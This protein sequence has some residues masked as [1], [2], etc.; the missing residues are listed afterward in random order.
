MKRI[1]KY[2]LKGEDKQFLQLPLNSRLLSVEEVRGNVALYAL[3]DDEERAVENYSIIIH[4]TG[5][6]SDDVK[7]YNFISTVKLQDGSIVF[8]VFVLKIYSNYDK[9]RLQN[10]LEEV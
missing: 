7:G 4:G 1:F 6:C 9:S 5:H 10:N 8:H 3:V 2:E